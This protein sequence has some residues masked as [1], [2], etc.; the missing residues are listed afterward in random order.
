M[1]VNTAGALPL[2]STLTDT[3]D[4]PDGAAPDPGR[5]NTDAA[6]VAVLDGGRLRL[7]GTLTSRTDTYLIDSAFVSVVVPAQ[8]Q[9]VYVSVYAAGHTMSPPA[10]WGFDIQAGVNTSVL[11]ASWTNDDGSSG[12]NGGIGYD[13]VGHAY[14]RLRSELTDIDGDT[15]I[16]YMCD[17]G[18]NPDEFTELLRSPQLFTYS[19]GGG[20]RVV[21][22]VDAGE[23]LLDNVNTAA[24]V[25]RLWLRLPDGSHRLVGVAG[26]PLQLRMPDGSLRAWPG[27]GFPLYIR[28]GDG[29]WQQVLS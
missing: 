13:P 3:F 17:A 8:P 12:S 18:P 14:L 7:S 28:A 20:F 22:R 19:A 9:D 10:T 4:G 2:A 15:Y 29:S 26:Q 27:S 23:V 25:S 21:A 24:A 1:S 6:A 5:W 11:F 16:T